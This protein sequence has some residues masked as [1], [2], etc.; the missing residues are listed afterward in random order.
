MF[1][2]TITVAPL[3]ISELG[4]THNDL[5][6]G[7]ARRGGKRLDM[8]VDPGVKPKDQSCVASVQDEVATRKED[9][10]RGRN[11]DGGS[12]HGSVKIVTSPGERWKRF[13]GIQTH[14]MRLVPAYASVCVNALV[15][16]M[17]SKQIIGSRKIQDLA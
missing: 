3:S 9:F 4:G 11:G 6:Q 14:T 1:G 7:E 10:A 2:F 16:Y 15:A 5:R 13:S 17:L 8:Y 12:T